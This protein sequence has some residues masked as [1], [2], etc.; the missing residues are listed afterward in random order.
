MTVETA[1]ER[2]QLP[3]GESVRLN[4]TVRNKSEDGLPM[5]LVRV[6]LPGGLS[7]QTWQLKELRDKALIA[8]YET[9]PREVNLYLRQLTPKQELRL[10]LDLLATVPGRYTGPAS[11]A[12]LYYTSEH[13][14]WADGVTVT[15]TP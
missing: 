4:V 1:L 6:G 13:K 11:R 10:P 2:G 14:S 5:T 7:F 3:L 9:G 15:I 12:Y 8:F